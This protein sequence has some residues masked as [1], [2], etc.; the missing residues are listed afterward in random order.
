MNTRVS[1]KPDVS[2]REFVTRLCGAAGVA[3]AGWPLSME[4]AGLAACP[5]VVFSKVYQTLKLDYA[6]S[7]ELTREAGLDGVDPAVREG[8]EVLP[9]NVDRDLPKY[10]DAIRSRDL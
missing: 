8:G 4:A 6:A 3:A 9:E 5:I 2:R 1:Q 10:A 7:A